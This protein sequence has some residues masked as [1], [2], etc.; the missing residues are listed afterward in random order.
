M[1]HCHSYD[2][3]SDFFLCSIFVERRKVLLLLLLYNMMLSPLD[4]NPSYFLLAKI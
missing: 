4:A 3:Y 1:A 2:L